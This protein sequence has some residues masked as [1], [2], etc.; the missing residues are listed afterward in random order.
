MSEGA[1]GTVAD[2]QPLMVRQRPTAGTF[3]LQQDRP[4]TDLHVLQVG[5]AL[6]YRRGIDGRPRPIAIFGAGTALGLTGVAGRPAAFS[7]VVQPGARTCQIGMEAFRRACAADAGLARGV[8]S[9]T[10]R[11]F[12]VIAGWSELMRL[13]GALRQVAY[14]LLLIKD[15]H[16]A[17]TVE[18]PTHTALSGLLGTTRET[19]ARCMAALQSDGCIR[20]LG[21]RRFL[22]HTDQLM[23]RVE[24][25][26]PELGAAR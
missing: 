4:M 5:T 15:V 26:E 22:L 24:G 17:R 2:L 3:L 1:P 10:R 25:V 12:S 6:V 14:A 13:K 9:W 18:L 7:V 20:P 21:R 16:G 8:G 11:S 23:R 19:V